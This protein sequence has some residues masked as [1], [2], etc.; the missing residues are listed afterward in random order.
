MLMVIKCWQ[1]E[2][3]RVLDVISQA[4]E[5]QQ[6]YLREKANEVP[7]VPPKVKIEWLT[8]EEQNSFLK[9]WEAHNRCPPDEV[10]FEQYLMYE[11]WHI[12]D[13]LRA[14]APDELTE[15][16]E[17]AIMQAK[18][19]AWEEW[20]WDDEW[21]WGALEHISGRARYIDQH[22]FEDIFTD[23]AVLVKSEYLISL[24]EDE[25]KSKDGL[26]FRR[27]LP[28]EA[29]FSSEEICAGVK[30]SNFIVVAIA[31][32]WLSKTKADEGGYHLK[33]LGNLLKEYHKHLQRENFFQTAFK[34]QS[35]G[36]IDVAIFIDFMCCREE[37]SLNRR[38]AVVQNEMKAYDDEQVEI[39]NA[40][41]MKPPPVLTN[42]EKIAEAAV[43][44][45]EAATHDT[46]F[47]E[48]THG[49]FFGSL[50]DDLKSEDITTLDQLLD[51]DVV[52]DTVLANI[53]AT[54]SEKKAYREA[55]DIHK[56]NAEKRK[57]EERTLQ[58]EHKAAERAGIEEAKLDEARAQAQS[59]KRS[60]DI[61]VSSQKFIYAHKDIQLWCL[62]RVPE[63]GVELLEPF[64]A[65]GWCIF[66]KAIATLQ[67]LPS[68]V[69]DM[70]IVSG[71]ENGT[72]KDSKD[73]SWKANIESV[74]HD[75]V[76]PPPISGTRF[77]DLLKAR[78]YAAAFADP[79]KDLPRALDLYDQAVA[80][81]ISSAE[82]LVY[83]GIAN[84]DIRDTKRFAAMLDNCTKLKRFCIGDS[85]TITDEGF[86]CI[87]SHLRHDLE[88][89]EFQKTKF[90]PDSAD[91]YALK[92]EEW[93][94]MGLKPSLTQLN[95]EK[96]M[97]GDAGAITLLP[98]L[99]STL[100][101]L[102][103]RCSKISDSGAFALAAA[104]SVNLCNIEQLDLGDNRLIGDIGLGSL[105]PALLG[106]E[107]LQV[108]CLDGCTHIST[109][110]VETY[111]TR[112]AIRVSMGAFNDFFLRRKAAIA[113]K[114]VE[115]KAKL[116]PNISPQDV[117]ACNPYEPL[118][119]SAGGT[120][121]DT[122]PV[123]ESPSF[124]AYFQMLETGLV[125]STKE[126][127]PGKKKPSDDD[128]DAT[129]NRPKPGE[130]RKELDLALLSADMKYR[131]RRP[132]CTRDDIEKAL[133]DVEILFYKERG[134]S[135]RAT[136]FTSE[137]AKI[138]A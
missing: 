32:P 87:V 94:A 84:W 65:R 105:A 9:I 73:W 50:Q 45:Q 62:S 37:E 136:F 99:P 22:Y 53:G 119:A 89:L 17:L 25:E 3:A 7:Y 128:A 107:D 52:T 39:A 122:M 35:C 47:Y 72:Y 113:L 41:K 77:R 8:E 13:R 92:L 98:K 91:N 114:M 71:L 132:N 95:L 74:C 27:D 40:E 135:L 6:I 28:V 76:H 79:S 110:V 61:A 48:G 4:I 85:R 102:N 108:L 46:K 33:I 69:Y 5:K 133:R 1:A 70:G 29:M 14:F 42:E 67:K 38:M 57:Q 56:R 112:K 138:D 116:A 106:C 24:S 82:E 111:T 51:P 127:K 54:R 121:K 30:G 68:S 34:D 18:D 60:F 59:D 58:R 12:S 20:D 21:D 88:T 19:V 36:N 126:S 49:H 104:L 26:P 83:S 64:D 66:A 55:V 75:K 93:Q 10:D 11:G 31:V 134:D 81:T 115:L 78:G 23:D 137:R 100:R 43:F 130:L 63:A 90:G 123:R 109:H 2:E 103:L 86:T 80:E 129:A 96:T 101:A 124:G 117:L 120:K 125:P 44:F 97:L 118:P 131:V 16:L 15:M